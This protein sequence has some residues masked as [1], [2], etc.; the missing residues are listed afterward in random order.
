[1]SLIEESVA[2]IDQALDQLSSEA[3][4]LCLLP[5]WDISILSHFLELSPHL[6]PRE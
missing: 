3:R 4:G 6:N 2:N 1:M 5:Y